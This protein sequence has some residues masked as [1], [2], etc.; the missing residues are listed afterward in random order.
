MLWV[1]KWRWYFLVANFIQCDVDVGLIM[2][3]R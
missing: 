2:N 3:Q 1:L